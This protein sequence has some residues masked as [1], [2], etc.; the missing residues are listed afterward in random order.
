VAGIYIPYQGQLVLYAWMVDFLVHWNG[1]LRSTPVVARE[2]PDNR[3][4]HFVMQ[5]RE[6]WLPLFFVAEYIS[7]NQ[8][9]GQQSDY[10]PEKSPGR[11]LK[12]SVFRQTA[13]ADYS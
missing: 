1:S 3:F 8:R 11:L 10:K 5:P 4:D 2:L 13:S 12:N 6:C 9:T 7:S